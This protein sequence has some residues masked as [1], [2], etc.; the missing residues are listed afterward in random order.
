MLHLRPRGSALHARARAATLVLA[1]VACLGASAP[2]DARADGAEGHVADASDVSAVTEPHDAE[3]AEPPPAGTAPVVT[4][5]R[6]SARMHAWCA[7]ETEALADSVCAFDGSAAGPGGR[8]GG[9]RRTLVI[10][11]HGVVPR[12]AGW[13]WTQQRAVL[14][15]AKLLKFTAIMP[16]GPGVGPRAA[17]GYA[18]PGS[19]AGQ[20]VE[21]ELIDQW[22]RARRALEARAGR[23]F[24]EVFV[25]GFSS[26]AYFATSL[27]LRGRLDVD[28]YVLV[29]G[30]SAAHL[31]SDPPRRPPV[32]IGVSTQDRATAP[33]A[34]ALGQLLAGR[35][36]A[37]RVDEE[38]VG[39]MISD[40]HVVHALTYLRARVDS[41]GG[42]LAQVPH[43]RPASN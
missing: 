17:A 9:D 35:G 4:T 26:G 19:T 28:G 29:A 11:L 33:G 15:E 22:S 27:A 32:F 41:G 20:P 31:V 25:L 14:R 7:P 36:W 13:Q 39:H 38:P 6:T 40:L 16:R 3:G 43:P 23:P 37:H 21:Q 18:W 34:R 2:V 12:D 10:F 5:A 1:L 24:D 30:G 42:R 8:R